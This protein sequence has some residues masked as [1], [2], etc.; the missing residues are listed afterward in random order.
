MD[1][2]QHQFEALVEAHAPDLYR[3][4]Y[5]LC[6]NRA[7]AE[8]LVQETLIRAWK[9]L[10]QLRD[11]DAARGWLITILRREC[12]RHYSRKQP[13]TVPLEPEGMEVWAVG[14]NQGADESDSLDILMLRQGLAALPAKY[15]E[16]LLLQV[17]VGFSCDEIAGQLGISPGAVMTRLFRARQALRKRFDSGSRQVPVRR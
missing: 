6:H 2:R 12:A 15:R 8:D 16:P 13:D 9:G 10:D 1:I 17:I 14:A 4:A 7:L 11:A 3:Y 5:W